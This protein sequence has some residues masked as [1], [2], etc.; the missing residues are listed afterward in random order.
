MSSK[1]HSFHFEYLLISTSRQIPQHQRARYDF[2]PRYSCTC[3]TS[4]VLP[5]RAAGLREAQ[6]H[7]WASAKLH[8]PPTKHGGRRE[9]PANQLHYICDYAFER[10]LTAGS[11]EFWERLVGHLHSLLLSAIPVQRCSRKSLHEGSFIGWMALWRRFHFPQTCAR[12]ASSRARSSDFDGIGDARA[13]PSTFAGI[14]SPTSRGATNTQPAV[15]AA[16]FQ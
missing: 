10:D 13:R 9:R 8:F 7:K 16:H 3:F 15:A 12:A 5:A 4:S 2:E 6:T 1:A 14:V 11:T